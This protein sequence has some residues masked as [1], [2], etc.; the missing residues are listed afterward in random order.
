MCSPDCIVACD[1]VWLYNVIM[2]LNPTTWEGL[3]ERIVERA[4][5]GEQPHGGT[6]DHLLYH[7]PV[8]AQ[9]T[10]AALNEIVD[11]PYASAADFVARTEWNEPKDAIS[12][13]ERYQNNPSEIG[14]DGPQIDNL[15][16]ATRQDIVSK[17]GSLLVTLNP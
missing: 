4:R 17:M 12:F 7:D 16:R 13:V 6:F 10:M 9:R 14:L 1:Q 3:G 8:T 2:R 11:P 5:H 15:E